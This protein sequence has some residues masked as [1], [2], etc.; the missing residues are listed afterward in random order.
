MIRHVLL[1]VAVLSSGL[2]IGASPVRALDDTPWTLPERPP[3]CTTEDAESGDVGHCLLAFYQDPS[4]TG[5]GVPPAPGVGDGWDWTG[6]RYNGSPALE[7]WETERDR[8]QPETSRRGGPGQFET[9]VAAQALFEGFLAEIAANGYRVYDAS[10]YSFRCTSGN[11]GW[12][13]P[14]R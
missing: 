9:H 10:G 7:S 5:W 14:L 11:G 6:S 3:V 4:D 8:R 12:E 1:A 2:V 13:L